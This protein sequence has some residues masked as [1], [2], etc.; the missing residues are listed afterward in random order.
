MGGAPP[1]AQS[2]ILHH[3]TGRYPAYAKRALRGACPSW[4]VL[5]R[6]FGVG[7]FR[8]FYR[9]G[10]R[11]GIT[12]TFR[13]PHFAQTH[14]R[15]VAIDGNGVSSSMPSLSK[16]MSALWWHNDDAAHAMLRPRTPWPR[17]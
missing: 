4:A 13:D 1:A 12:V 15:R 3:S 6:P 8:S 11:G 2:Q 17:R 14:R 16:V 9:A 10:H 5:G 7:L